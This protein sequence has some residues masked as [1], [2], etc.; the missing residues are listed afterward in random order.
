PRRREAFVRQALTAL[1]LF[2]RD[3]Q[4]ILA[5]DHEG[6]DRVQIVDEYT[7]RVMPDRSWEHGLHQMIEVKEGLE[8]SGSQD[9]RARISYQRFFRRYHRLAGMTGTAREVSAELW[10]DYD[11]AVVPIPPHRPCQRR[12]LGERVYAT[13][14][15]KWSAVAE[16][17][18]DLA[19][20]GRAVLVGTRSV[21][22]SER[23]SERLVERGVPHR[24]LNARQDADEAEIV[25]QA[26]HAGRVTVATNMAGR[27]TDI[28]LGVGVAE[29][30]GLHVL[31]TE[32]HD[33]SRIDRQLFGR[34]ARQ[35]D[36]GTCESMVSLEDDL[37]LVYGGSLMA[38]ARWVSG[39]L[40]QPLGRL[41]LSQA[42]SRAGRLHA[43]IRHQLL[44][45]DERRDV[46]LAFSGR[47]D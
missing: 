21:A 15:A 8:P 9:P 43:R 27:G 37:A 12:F 38:L 13:A 18:A 16:R 24:V 17:I 39:P 35:G 23:L 10:N 5:K 3:Q 20:D 46:Q 33:A 7:G 28:V 45:A 19:V 30:G 11:L 14:E 47:P 1:H 31:A 42:Q 44:K 36:P 2:H 22:A 29:T 41:A 34:C 32:R 26:G 40:L 6:E 4:Y 25:A